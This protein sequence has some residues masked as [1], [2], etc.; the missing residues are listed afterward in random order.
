M[1]TYFP[2][3]LPLQLHLKTK[4]GFAVIRLFSILVFKEIG[5]VAHLRV[6]PF[7]SGSMNLLILPDD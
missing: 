5:S 6:S 4:T 3:V 2:Y 1:L 7:V